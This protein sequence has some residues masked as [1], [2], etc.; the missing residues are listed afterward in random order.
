MRNF[1]AAR[2]AGG[3]DPRRH[4]HAQCRQARLLDRH[5]GEKPGQLGHPHLGHAGGISEQEG[6][7][8]HVCFPATHASSAWRDQRARVPMPRG[9]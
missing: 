5:L 6:Q 2:D 1:P 3:D 9:W 8:D 4:R 7:V